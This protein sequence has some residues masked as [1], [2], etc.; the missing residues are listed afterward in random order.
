MTRVAGALAALA[1]LAGASL[2]QAQPVSVEER[3]TEMQVQRAARA[4]QAAFL[5]K[6]AT[7]DAQARQPAL[8]NGSDWFPAH[9]FAPS[10]AGLG[11]SFQPL[12]ANR[13]ALCLTMPAGTAARHAALARAFALA[14]LAPA[15]SDCQAASAWPTP[16]ASATVSARRELDRRDVPVATLLPPTGG[17]TVTGADAQAV[18]RPGLTLLA[19]SGQSSAAAVLTVTNPMRYARPDGSSCTAQ[20]AGLP[21]TD[22]APL[23]SSLTEVSARPGFSVTHTCS[24]IAAGASCTVSL[25]YANAGER[26]LS[27]PLRLAFS[28]GEVAAIGV[29]GRRSP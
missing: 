28:T 26:Y 4:L 5:R 14:G 18:T 8:A 10:L 15:A 23:A 17:V 1:L 25:V 24:S 7:L 29:L 9:G 11:W 19:A 22:C 2:A 21:E 12:D 16:G 6:Y 20:D 3:M 27:M 13:G